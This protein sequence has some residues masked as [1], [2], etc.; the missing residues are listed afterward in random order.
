MPTGTRHS[1]IA[2]ERV[3]EDIVTVAIIGNRDLRGV[4]VANLEGAVLG[5]D[6]ETTEHRGVGGDIG[7]RR[8]RRKRTVHGHMGSSQV[9][10]PAGVG[11]GELSVVLGRSLIVI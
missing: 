2:I 8:L 7:S 10:L 6:I 5:L 11:T 4:V 3:D 1:V 9:G